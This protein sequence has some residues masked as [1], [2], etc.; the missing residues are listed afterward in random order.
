[1]QDRQQRINNCII[2]YYCGP[3]SVGQGPQWVP[4]VNPFSFQHSVSYMFPSLDMKMFTESNVLGF[5]EILFLVRF[6]NL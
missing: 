5:L 1:M 2:L 3:Q 4:E 6:V